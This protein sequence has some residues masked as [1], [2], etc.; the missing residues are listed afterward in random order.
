MGH[1]ML[2]G[3][4]IFVFQDLRGRF[5][6][7]GDYAMYR[8]PRGAYNQT[9]TDETTDAWD[10][11]DWL[12]K[13]VPDN[14][15]KVGVWGTSYPGWLT[16]AAMRDP[17]PAL[18][19]AVP[20]NPVV[21]VWKADDWF[22][23]GAFRFAYSFDFIYAME[24]RKGQNVVYPYGSRDLVRVALPAGVGRAGARRTGGR[25]PRD[26]AAPHREPELHALL[27]R[28]RRR[29][30]VRQPIPLVPALT[31]HGL[32]DQ[33]DIYGAPAAYAALERLDPAN[34]HNF[35]AAGPW[36]HGQHFADGSRLG[37]LTFDED[38]ARR[39]REDVLTPFLRRF[40]KGENV[41]RAGAR[42]R[43]R[44]RNQ[45]VAA[46]RPVAARR[47]DPAPV[48]AG[49]WGAR[50][51]TSLRGTLV[52]RVH[53]RPREAGAQCATPALGLRLRQPASQSAPGA[54][55]SSRTSGSWTAVPTWPHGRA[56][57]STRR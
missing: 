40:L 45:P 24:S 44:N 53:L 49:R 54:A 33:E 5:R 21:D 47:R 14:T 10:T 28:L 37:A 9:T 27:A 6:S 38:T 56:R 13:H 17:H 43:L 4:Y 25:A 31:V 48:P 22:H 1:N 26:V 55:G 12:V 20:F 15:G 52:H 30:L 50:F 18:A 19:A 57:R 8:V 46:V 16:L 3:G 35:F 29:P 42:H 51:H 32:W 7:E 23:W 11:I 39:F 36:Y 34:D 41:Q 2:D